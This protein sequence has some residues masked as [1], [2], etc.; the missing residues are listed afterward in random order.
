MGLIKVRSTLLCR[1]GTETD[2]CLLCDQLRAG[3][4]GFRGFRI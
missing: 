1:G 3:G 2:Q 4:L